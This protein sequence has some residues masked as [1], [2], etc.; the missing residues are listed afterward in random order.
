MNKLKMFLRTIVAIVICLGLGV[1]AGTAV[2]ATNSV[3]G[4]MSGAKTDDS[5]ITAKIKSA[6]VADRNVDAF[7]I[8]VET[9]QGHV[10]LSGFVDRP[11]QIDR[12]AR[13]VRQVEGVRNVDNRVRVRR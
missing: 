10:L 9:R 13:I 2:G 5:V 1:A 8:S 4:S 6:L 12:A 3:G 7:D 11:E